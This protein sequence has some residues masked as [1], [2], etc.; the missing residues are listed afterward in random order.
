MNNLNDTEAPLLTDW[1]V[2]GKYSQIQLLINQSDFTTATVNPFVGSE[3]SH[4]SY[5]LAHTF[6]FK[7]EN[8]QVESL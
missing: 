2:S 8:V 6:F 3:Q 1:L 7:H 4:D 5:V